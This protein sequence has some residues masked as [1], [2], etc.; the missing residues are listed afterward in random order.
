[1]SI[2]NLEISVPLYN[3]F[4]R[5]NAPT[6]GT[7]NLTGER[8]YGLG[9]EWKPFT[10]TVEIDWNVIAEHYCKGGEQ[11]LGFRALVITVNSQLYDPKEV[12][13]D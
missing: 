3:Y 9:D 8:S 12:P 4:K 1:M 10:A 11:T 5:G 2:R 13:L 6:Q 7:F